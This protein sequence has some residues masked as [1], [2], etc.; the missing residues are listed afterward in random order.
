[1]K[2]KKISLAF[3]FMMVLV[4]FAS[5]VFAVTGSIIDTTQ[6][7][8]LTITTREQNNGSTATTTATVISGVTYALY[9]VD[10]V[11]GTTV[12]TTAQAET[13]IAS[14]S[15]VSTQT[16]AANTGVASFTNLDLGRYYAKVTDYPTGSSQVPESFLVNIPMT[17][18]A[19]TGWI[20]N[21]TV[22]PKVK[23]ARG[24]VVLTKQDANNNNAALSGVVFT[25]Q[26]STDNCATWTDYV[27]EGASTAL[28][29]TTGAAGTVSLN[30]YPITIGGQPA[31]FRF[32]EKSVPDTEYVIDNSH[33]DYVYAQAD[34]K[35]IVVHADGTSEA[36]AVEG[37]L[38]VTNEKPVVT[39]TVKNDDNSYTE[40][41]SA[42]ATDTIS[43]NVNAT[44]PS[45]IENM[46]TFTLKDELP[47]GLKDRTN[48]VVKGVSGTTK[49]TLATTAYTKTEE[50]KVLTITFVPAQIKDYDAVEVTYDV[51]LD[52]TKA[53]LGE[54][55]NVNTAT[56]NYTNKVNTDGTEATKKDITDE[57]TVLTGGVKI[58][59]VNASEES[60]DGAKFKIATSQANAVAGTFVK[61]TDG[62][63]I[64][65]TTATTTGLATINGL[66]YE[67]DGTARNY[68]LVETQAPT[69]TDGGE[70]KAYTL[71][72]APVQVTVDGTSHNSEVKV[73]NRKPFEL[74]LTGG[75]GTMIFVVVGAAFVI[76]SKTMKKEVKE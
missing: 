5:T 1:M 69:Y 27:P 58:H 47:D 50:G 38:T 62:N 36:A 3:V 60:L 28:T 31:Y 25:V 72:T 66:A 11:D 41:A 76:V 8:S 59:K 21:V 9:R 49:T 61:G 2:S 14:L 45:A 43:F 74:P 57:A 18:V 48:V 4:T 15:P 75:I 34:G 46:T 40:Q 73:V 63:D 52:M 7:G 51:K 39:K 32:V 19:G 70:T 13:A 16:T 12:T 71:L 54:D 10:T 55:G 6:K 37:T 23:T 68:W 64:E 20:Y 53:E 17:N 29:L 67:D 35:T 30:D 24:N 44:V 33:L 65:V 22:E 42:S 56:L 26:V